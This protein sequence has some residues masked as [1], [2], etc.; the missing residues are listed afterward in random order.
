MPIFFIWQ[1]INDY[2]NEPIGAYYDNSLKTWEQS[3]LSC[4]QLGAWDEGEF[5]VRGIRVPRRPPNYPLDQFFWIGARVQ[6]TPWFTYQGEREREKDRERER[7]RLFRLFWDTHGSTKTWHFQWD[8]SHLFFLHVL[9][10]C[11]FSD[12]FHNGRIGKCMVI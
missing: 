4:Q 12:V 11:Q 3:S 9:I 10:L 5:S 6:Q 2:H 8:V 1:I 7:E